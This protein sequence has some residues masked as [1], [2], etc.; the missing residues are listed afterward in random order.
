MV[1]AASIYELAIDPGI[2]SNWS[3]IVG[4]ILSNLR[5]SLDHIAWALATKHACDQGIKLCEGKA[6]RVLFPLKIERVAKHGIDG[7]SKKDLE[8]LLPEAHSAVES[9]QPYNRTNRP[10]LGLLGVLGYLTNE[11]K[12]RKVTPV[13]RAI[14]VALSEK[15]QPIVTRLNKPSKLPFLVTDSMR[16][17]ID[18]RTNFD[19]V[20]NVPFLWP[21]YF[22]VSEFS[23]LHDLIRHEVIPAFASF[24]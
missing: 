8:L 2:K 19:V 5:A 4:D 22:S 20:L 7:L 3:L 11:D 13:L 9:F 24:F 17:N 23:K 12:H 16:N 10:E 21:N 18:I 14:S 15:E 6:R 1:E